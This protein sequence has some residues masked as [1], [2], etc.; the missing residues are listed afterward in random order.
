MKILLFIGPHRAGKSTV[1]RMLADSLPNAVRIDLDEEIGNLYGCDVVTVLGRLGKTR[2]SRECGDIVKSYAEHQSQEIGFVAVGAG[3]ILD[4][5]AARKWL[6]RYT[7]ICLIGDPTVLYQRAEPACHSSQPRYIAIE[8]SED[9][10]RLYAD[11]DFIVHVDHMSPEQTAQQI[12]G[13]IQSHSLI[14]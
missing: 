10:R 11:A 2:F 9:R 4:S 3:A 12:L 6:H 1:V 7:V 13:F 5:T 8:F 14:E